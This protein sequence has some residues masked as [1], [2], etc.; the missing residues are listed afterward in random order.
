MYKII[1]M[2]RKEMSEMKRITVEEYET[3]FPKSNEEYFNSLI[4]EQKEEY[5]IL[6]SLYVEL[7]I[8]YLNEKLNLQQYEEFMKNYELGF[9]KVSEEDMD[10]YQYLCSNQFNYLYIRNNIYIERLNNEQKKYLRSRFQNKDYS[11]NEKDKEFVSNTCLMVMLEEPTLGNTAKTN[12]GPLSANYLVDRNAIVIGV[13]YDENYKD[14]NETDDEWYDKYEE[15]QEE[16]NTMLEFMNISFNKQSKLVFSA[17][18][19]DELSVKKKQQIDELSK[20]K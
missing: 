8:Q 20:I 14:I 12:Y 1:K 10:I 16:I 17:I 9:P 18:K 7:L 13:R 2:V 15:R 3:R 6:Y 11:L 5:L 19:Y 4:N